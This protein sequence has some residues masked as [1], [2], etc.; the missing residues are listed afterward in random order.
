VKRR[1]FASS[2]AGALGTIFVG[3]SPWGWR[4]G[5][6]RADRFV[7]RWSWA[8][9]QAVRVCVFAGSEQEGLDACA[10]AL[11]ELRRVEVHLTLF[12]EASDLCELNRRAGRRPM[13]VAADL[14]AVLARARGFER[15]TGG[16]FNVAVE[17]LMRAWGFHRTRRASPSAAEIAEARE[18]V[19]TAV[20]EL[21]GDRAALPNAHTRLDFGS[22]GVGYGI[23]RMLVVL[24]ERGIHSAFIDVSGDCAALGSPPGEAGWLVEIADPD[25]EGRTVAATRLRDA[26]LSTAANTES[27]VRYG[28]LVVGHV[29]NPATGWP[30][31]ALRQV[32]VVTRTPTEA[33]VLSTA[34]LVSGRRPPGVL[35][36]YSVRARGELVRRWEVRS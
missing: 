19:R 36:A 5:R 31:H 6:L 2:L 30:A 20:I 33:D 1:E 4:G 27:V 23:E 17:P 18:A 15:L 7:E 3:R 24:R 21:D 12:D 25:R 29:M 13:R 32:S 34:I 22:I 10:A 9:G 35:R 28:T 8:M 16:A 14:H 26:A 11:A